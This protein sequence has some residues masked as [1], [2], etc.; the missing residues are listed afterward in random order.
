VTAIPISES[1]GKVFA[2]SLTL[3]LGLI[4][5][6]LKGVII[7]NNLLQ[8]SIETEHKLRMSCGMMI[9]AFVKGVIK[10]FLANLIGV[11]RFRL[12]HVFSR[13]ISEVDLWPK[14]STL[15]ISAGL[16]EVW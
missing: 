8:V 12:S 3:S 16:S 4:L 1:N 5:S 7:L 10:L 15:C 11:V 14:S 6:P 2:H 9:R 13:L